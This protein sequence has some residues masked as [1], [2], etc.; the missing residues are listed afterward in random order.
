MIKYFFFYIIYVFEK[1]A[2]KIKLLHF[3]YNNLLANHF[4]NQ[5][6]SY[7]NAKKRL[8]I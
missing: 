8:L 4:K 3:Y 1:I 2:L 5:E 6:N 7:F